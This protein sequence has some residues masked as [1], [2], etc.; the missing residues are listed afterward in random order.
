MTDTNEAAKRRGQTQAFPARIGA[1]FEGMDL[2]TYIA[3]KVMAGMAA[4][5]GARGGNEWYAARAVEMADALLAELS[6][7]SP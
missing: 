6:K 1:A 2:R 5:T 7:E 4:N 3:A